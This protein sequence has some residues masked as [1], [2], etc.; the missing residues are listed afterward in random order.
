MR[1]RAYGGSTR[2]LSRQRAGIPFLSPS[3]FVYNQM[4]GIDE[5]A[6]DRCAR[7]QRR[8]TRLGLWVKLRG[9]FCG[10]RGRVV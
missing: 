5:A 4:G 9:P 10:A 8:G 1:P 7:C 6:L 3:L 2:C